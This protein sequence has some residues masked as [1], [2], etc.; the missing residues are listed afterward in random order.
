MT[1]PLPPGEAGASSFTRRSTCDDDADGWADI[2]DDCPLI[3]SLDNLDRDGVGDVSFSR[4]RTLTG[5]YMGW[6][7][8]SNRLRLCENV[9][10]DT[11]VPL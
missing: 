9:R 1:D 4:K 10:F 2:D 5:G 7:E 8:V 3:Y 11:M 6:R